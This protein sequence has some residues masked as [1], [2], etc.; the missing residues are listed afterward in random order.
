MSIINT[1][2]NDFQSNVL[3]SEIPVI[4]DFW[5]EWCGP[6]KMIG[7]ILEELSEEYSDKIKVVKI[8]VDKCSQTAIQFSVRSIPTLMIFEN[9]S[10]KA[11]HIGALSKAQLKEFIDN[12]I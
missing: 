2:D 8:D 10:V 5:A 7:P 11:Q 9:G 12:N 6:C 1:E 3:D 4:A